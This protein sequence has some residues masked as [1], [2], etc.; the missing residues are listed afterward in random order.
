[1]KLLLLPAICFS[2]MFASNAQ[3]HYRPWTWYGKYLND[4]ESARRSY[5]KNWDRYVRTR[6]AVRD[7]YKARNK[8]EHALDRKE[9]MLD[10]AERAFALKQREEKLRAAGVLPPRHPDAGAFG[11]D[12]KRFKNMDEFRASPEYQTMLDKRRMNELQRNAEKLAAEQRRQKAVDFGRMWAKM[13]W[14]SKESWSRRSPEYKARVLREFKDPDLMW[15]R[16]EDDRNR[17]F[18]ESRPYLIP[19]AGKNGLPPL[20]LDMRK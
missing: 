13:S 6:W 8:P 18:Y 9:R 14:L 11:Y 1:M 2:L 19:R 20:P 5:I 10:Q 16:L 17:R 3:A 15:K 7:E 12:N 4:R